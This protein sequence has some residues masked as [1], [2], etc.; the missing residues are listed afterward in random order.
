MGQPDFVYLDESA[1]S[2]S[3]RVEE[4]MEIIGDSAPG[5][6]HESALVVRSNT[7]RPQAAHT[8]VAS[9]FC[10]FALVSGLSFS[11]TKSTTKPKRAR[12]R[13]GCTKHASRDDAASALA[14]CQRS[15][16]LRWSPSLDERVP[17]CRKAR[18][19]LQI[20]RSRRRGEGHPVGGCI[21]PARLLDVIVIQHH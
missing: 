21:E 20:S 18:S 4:N 3:G 9:A 16:T 2:T 8:A 12:K 13:R 17:S 15:A 11:A 14:S 7:K 19:S 10:T 5:V 1:D 6:A